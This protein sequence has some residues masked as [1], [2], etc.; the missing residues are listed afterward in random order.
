MKYMYTQPRKERFVMSRKIIRDYLCKYSIGFKEKFRIFPL[1][2]V[3]GQVDY[4][5]HFYLHDITHGKKRVL[6]EINTHFNLEDVA[7]LRLFLD[8]Y[9]RLYHL[10]LVVSGSHIQKWNEYD[11]GIQAVFHDIWSISNVEFLMRHLESLH[12]NE[13]LLK[14]AKH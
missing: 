9:G 7:T 5:P 2:S 3:T 14:T 6:L 13:V 12:T 1:Q 11:D 4:M 8:T 10:I